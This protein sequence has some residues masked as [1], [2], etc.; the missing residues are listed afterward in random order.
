MVPLMSRIAWE[1]S[2]KVSMM[3]SIPSILREP[4][5]IGKAKIL[6]AQ[7]LLESWST[8][9]FQVRDKIEQSGRDQ[10]WEFDR[11]K[12]FD[13][14][15]YMAL[16]CADLFEIAK[17]ME[18]FYSIFGAELKSV[19]GDPEAIDEVIRRVDAIII[20]FE[21]IT[22]DFFQKA[23]HSAWEAVMVR[24]RDQIVQI[25]DTA[26]QFIDASFKKLRSAEGAFDLLQNIKNIKSRESINKQLMGKWYEILDQYAREVDII[27][28]IFQRLKDSPP[29]SKNESPVAGAIAWSHSLFVRIKHTIVRFQTLKEMLASDQGKAVTRKYLTVAKSMRAYEEGLYHAWALSVENITLQNLKKNILVRESKIIHGREAPVERICCNFRIELLEVIKETKYLKKMNLAVPEAAANVTL[30]EDKYTHLVELV[31]ITLVSYH[32]LIDPLDASERILFANDIA[33]LNMHLKPGFTRLNWNSLGIPEF[34]GKCNQEISKLASTV[35]QIRKNS[36]SIHKVIDHI[37]KAILVRDIPDLPILDVHEL[38]DCLRKHRN[39]VIESLVV[40]YKTIAPLLLKTESLVVKTNTGTSPALKEY[41]SYWEK[42]IFA[43]LNYMVVSN[44][45]RFEIGRAHV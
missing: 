23:H 37:A 28:E 1:I 2:N 14:T 36:K 43:A 13:V 41:Y 42:R 18:Q 32:E 19:T 22:F 15:N 34:L 26:K 10:R 21:N 38:F 29:I 33:T 24:F 35:H 11:K 4:A 16:Q 45:M 30:Q 31:N 9:Y 7:A 12:L 3:I 5:E 39:T 27:D 25:E 20:P 17:V 44:L 40:K 6:A 8:V